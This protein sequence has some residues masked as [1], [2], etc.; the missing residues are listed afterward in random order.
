MISVTQGPKNNAA[1]AALDYNKTFEAGAEGV[2]KIAQA[3][4][5]KNASI[6]KAV[7]D[8]Q[9]QMKESQITASK[10]QGAINENPALFEGLEEGNNLTSKS[11]K[12]ILQGNAS[13]Q[14]FN[15]LAA[16][17]DSANT[18]KEI[19][20]KTKLRE[21][22]TK[23]AQGTAE[24]V[25]MIFSGL[26]EDDYDNVSKADVTMAF[27]KVSEKYDDPAIKN[28]I[29]NA[30]LQYSKNIIDT[31]DPTA[32]I[33]NKRDNA[34]DLDSFREA[35]LSV[36]DYEANR[37]IRSN[38]DLVEQYEVQDMYG[39]AIGVR[40]VEYIAK[41]LGLTRIEPKGGAGGEANGTTSEV[42][43]NELNIQ[44]VEQ[45]FLVGEE[46][47]GSML[48]ED[49]VEQMSDLAQKAYMNKFPLQYAE[50]GSTEQVESNAILS[51]DEIKMATISEPVK[52]NRP[53]LS[54]YIAE[55]AQGFARNTDPYKLA[56]FEFEEDYA[57]YEKALIKYKEQKKIYDKNNRSRR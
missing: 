20:E 19:G 32:D 35:Y 18:Q 30:G 27:M 46:W 15:N 41:T 2:R 38:P 28:A 24:A 39:N 25:S 22:N 40:D 16:Y 47:T 45:E 6:I 12:S 55:Y 57:I 3:K 37:V 5:A 13:Q 33:K 17:I 31:L 1:L 48:T 56:E 8:M 44:E 14:D 43:V 9:T 50:P 26:A 34:K 54:S 11:F 51:S 7:E 52:P 42:P 36:N 23:I 4:E 29:N 53:K 49:Q 10:V 21:D